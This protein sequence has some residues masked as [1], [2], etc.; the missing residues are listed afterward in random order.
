MAK[1]KNAGFDEVFASLKAILKKL[2]PKLL[3][4]AD[5]DSRYY[6]NTH[7]VHNKRPVFFGAVCVMKNYVSYHLMPIYGCPDLIDGLSP[8]LKAHMQGKACFNFKSVEPKLFKE[9]AQLT[10]VG[11]DRFKKAGFA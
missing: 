1:S 10:K 8:E 4:Q 9:L 5:T 2:E 11:Y 6:L 7:V 3:V